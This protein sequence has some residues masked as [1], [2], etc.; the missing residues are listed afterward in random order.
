MKKFFLLGLFFI[1]LILP[2]NVNAHM[3][4]QP[5]FFKINGEYSDLY[6]VPISS[7]VNFDLP[8]DLAKKSHVVGEPLQ[9]EMD[10]NQLPILPE[11][12]DQ[13]TF[14]WEFGDGV[15]AEGFKNTHT[16]PKAGSYFMHVMAKYRTD[17]P[18]LI[19]S[20]LINVLPDTNYKLPEAKLK[21]NGQ[22]SQDPLTDIIDVDF[23]Q[24]ISFDSSDSTSIDGIADMIFNRI[25]H[26]GQSLTS[27]AG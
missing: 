21:V 15:R 7:S 6:P 25:E 20:T 23:N 1:F 27:S 4:G 3:V 14:F 10:L 5:P 2:G 24:P 18:Q 17:E 11:V 26:R 12:I 16:Y 13:T 9:M 19:Q 22:A 8:Q